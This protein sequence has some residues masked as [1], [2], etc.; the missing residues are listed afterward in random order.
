MMNIKFVLVVVIS[1]AV[2]PCLAAADDALRVYH[3]GNSLTR[4]VPLE[5]VL[6]LF[7]SK[8][9]R[10]EKACQEFLDAGFTNV[11]S[12][13]GGTSAWDAAGLPVKRGKKAISLERQVRIC[14]GL[15]TLGGSVAAIVTGSAY[16]AGIPAFIGAG[17]TFAGVTDT[18]GMGMMLAKM[19]WNQ[20][21]DDATC[22][23]R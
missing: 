12:V 8:G 1:A 23:V 19:P 15:I 17:L 10:S 22:S 13:E 14:A 5:R 9:S 20:V 2:L 7:E 11:V 4:N 3:I 6:Q 18:C 21:K 16:L